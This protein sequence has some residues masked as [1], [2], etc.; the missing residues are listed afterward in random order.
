MKKTVVLTLVAILSVVLMGFMVT[1]AAAQ[2]GGTGTATLSSTSGTAGGSVTVSG[3]G[4]QPGETVRIY[5]D[6]TYLG[7]TTADSAGNFSK[8]VTIPSSADEGT[9]TIKAVGA[10]RTL[11]STFT[12]TSGG[13]GYAYTGAKIL[14][15]LLAG[16][17]F[18]GLGMVV[19]KSGSEKALR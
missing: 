17:A 14:F 12:V 2:Y 10:E 19:F 5:F 15:G 16:L 4:F 1:S 18:V 11:T 3:S 7:S 6:D 13:L 8:T 9:H